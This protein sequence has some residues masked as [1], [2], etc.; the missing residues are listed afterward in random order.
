MIDRSIGVLG[1]GLVGGSI[2]KKLRATRKVFFWDQDFEATRAAESLG[3][4]ESVENPSDLA[5]VADLVVVCLPAG[6]VA[7]H[8]VLLLNAGVKTITDVASV[9]GTIVEKISEQVAKPTNYIGGHPLAGSEQSG[10]TAADAD[11]FVGASW[12]LTPTD[13]TGQEA[14]ESVRQMVDELG[15]DVLSIDLAIHDRLMAEVSHLPQLAASALM[16]MAANS[17]AGSEAVLR[18]AAGGFRD[19]TRIAASNPTMWTDIVQANSRAIVDTIDS[20]LSSLGDLRE[21]I[22]NADPDKIHNFFEDAQKAR[23]NLPV[24]LP[25]ETELTELRV[26]VPD[27]PGMLAE[28]TAL[29]G[30]LG[31]NVADL[32]IAHSAEGNS[33]VVVLMI[34]TKNVQALVERLVAKGYQVAQQDL[35]TEH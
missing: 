21:L 15:A 30:G 27:K 35:G 12:I 16:N 10:F 33:G 11:L 31:I 14:F 1:L 22:L 28:I 9:K 7:E 34:E 19:M 32:E 6:L 24:G 18:L 29:A 4:G 26:R 2:A 17:P 8:V 3:I 13:Y 25:P 20:Y 23:V 5:Q